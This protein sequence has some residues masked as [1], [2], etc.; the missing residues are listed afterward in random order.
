MHF[1]LRFPTGPELSE[2]LIGSCNSALIWLGQSMRCRP[3]SCE[4]TAIRLIVTKKKNMPLSVFLENVQLV[5]EHDCK[6]WQKDWGWLR[7]YFL[8]WKKKI[9]HLNKSVHCRFKCELIAF[10]LIFMKLQPSLNIGISNIY[11]VHTVYALN[12]YNGLSS[13]SISTHNLLSCFSPPAI[14]NRLYIS[15]IQHPLQWQGGAF[16]ILF[17]K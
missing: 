8:C 11:S 9:Q 3:A 13:V 5:P 14:L 16:Q 4:H 10:A 6:Y 2:P 1:D 12:W 17:Q 15:P 7:C